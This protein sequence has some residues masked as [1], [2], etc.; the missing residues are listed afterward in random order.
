MYLSKNVIRTIGETKT[1]SALWTK[2]EKQYV[3]KTTPN[4]C[5]LLKQLFSSKMDP[6]ANLDDNLNRFTKLTHDLTNCDEKLSQDQLAMILLN[7]ISD[8]YRDIKVAL[9]YG[10]AKLTTEIIINALKKKAL[11]IKSESKEN[12]NGDTLLAKGRGFSK[13][14]YHSKHLNENKQKWDDKGKYKNK[15]KGKK[16]VSIVGNSD[17]LI[18]DCYKTKMSQKKK[19][20]DVGDVALV[21]NK[22]KIEDGLVLVNGD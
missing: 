12:H 21:Y 14:N 6:F 1:T 3:T 20:H 4:K 9:E 13:P 16:N 2:L 15:V 17:I 19:K 10:R 22:D 5:Y 11:E 7:S 18:K 8:K